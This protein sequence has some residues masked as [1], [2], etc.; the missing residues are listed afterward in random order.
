VISEET[1]AI[2]RGMLQGV[3]D[4]GSGHL[5]QIPGYTVAGKTGTSQKVDPETGTYGREYVASFIG[6]APATDPEYVTLIAV[7]EPERTYWGE[8]AAAPA[9]RKVTSFAL[10]YFNVP[11]DRTRGTSP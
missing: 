3:V 8:L 7:D 11:P 2:V 5:A 4:E 6:F 9:F 1:S 10:G